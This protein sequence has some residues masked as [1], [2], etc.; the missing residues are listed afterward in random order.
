MDCIALWHPTQWAVER[1]VNGW[2]YMVK[3]GKKEGR[4]ICWPGAV[5]VV[6]GSVWVV[7]SRS[8]QLQEGVRCGCCWLGFSLGAVELLVCVI[9][10]RPESCELVG[11]YGE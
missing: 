6:S 4:E 9:S 10:F 8:C 7:R 5:Q 2:V 3:V 1:R 11:W